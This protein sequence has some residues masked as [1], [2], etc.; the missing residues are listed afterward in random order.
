MSL[1]IPLRLNQPFSIESEIETVAGR[2]GLIRRVTV[3]DAVSAPVQAPGQPG[4]PNATEPIQPFHTLSGKFKLGSSHVN[5]VLNIDTGTLP[6]GLDASLSEGASMT[7]STKT[8]LLSE[9]TELSSQQ[10]HGARAYYFSSSTTST[11]LNTSDRTEYFSGYFAEYDNYTEQLHLGEADDEQT[12][13]RVSMQMGAV[14]RLSEELVQRHCQG[15]A[16]FAIN[17]AKSTDALSIPDAVFHSRL[18]DEEEESVTFD[19]RHTLQTNWYQSCLYIGAMPKTLTLDWSPAMRLSNSSKGSFFGRMPYKKRMLYADTSSD[20]RETLSSPTPERPVVVDPGSSVIVLDDEFVRF[21][22]SKGVGVVHLDTGEYAVLD[23]F[24][25]DVDKFPE[26]RV[27]FGGQGEWLRI[28]SAAIFNWRRAHRVLVT[29][30][31]LT[32]VPLTYPYSAPA[33][34]TNIQ[35]PQS[36]G[37]EGC[38]FDIMGIPA[39]QCMYAKW[40]NATRAVPYAHFCWAQK[41][42][43]RQL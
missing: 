41:E 6:S 1:I 36:M 5:M 17:T 7:G 8:W 38:D 3:Q 26:L 20:P 24:S 25:K 39:L 2:H 16:G 37:L 33:R 19:V 30:H 27:Q 28:D 42:F 35:S 12:G 15:I 14:T 21:F 9:L 32:K 23:S 31:P 29:H 4:A 34:M 43:N 11:K 40:S 10:V 13:R 22:Y 18:V